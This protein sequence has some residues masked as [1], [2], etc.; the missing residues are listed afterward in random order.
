MENFLAIRI[1]VL[2]RG[3]ALRVILMP[4]KLVWK[5]LLNSAC[6]FV[7]LWMVNAL[8][9]YTGLLLPVNPVTAAVAGFFGLPGMA[10]LALA[11]VLL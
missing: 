7:C 4:V 11:Q 6:G 10:V 1:P 9:P 5:L 8:G 3:G 2:L